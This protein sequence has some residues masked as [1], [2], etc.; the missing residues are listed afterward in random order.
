MEVNLN[1][2]KMG[3]CFFKG[4]VIFLFAL[5]CV[6]LIAW[7]IQASLLLN[8]DVSWLMHLT[9]RMLAGGTYGKDF[10]EANPPM[11]LYLYIPPV[12]VSHLF[13][14]NIIL[15][16]RLYVFFLSS[17]SLF[18][19]YLSLKKIISARY[20]FLFVLALL[21]LIFPSYEFG[22]REHLLIILIMPWLLMAVV[23]LQGAPVNFVCAVL[24]GFMAGVGFSIKPHFLLVFVLV[25][26]YYYWKLRSMRV[27]AWLAGSV[28][29][30]YGLSIFL[31]QPE[32]ISLVVTYAMLNYYQGF[33][34]PWNVLFLYPCAYFCCFVLLLYYFYGSRHTLNT[35]LA[36]ALC[37]FLVVWF[38]QRTIWYYHFLPALS[39]AVL[40][41][42]ILFY[43]A[44]SNSLAMRRADYFFVSILGLVMFF[45]PLY[46]VG[47]TLY[48]G[49]VTYKK[50]LSSLVQY[51]H[52]NAF[53]KKIYF[54]TTTTVY[55][56]PAVDYAGSFS[57][58]RFA[59]TGF[60]PGILKNPDEKNIRD[61]FI[62]GVA[63]DLRIKKP[64][65]IF[66]DVLSEKAH[67]D[68]IQFDY[69]SC[70]SQNKNFQDAWKSYH[71]RETI[72]KEDAYKF[73]VYQRG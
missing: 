73:E 66:V 35:V 69:L 8:W 29:V 26:L 25:E 16:L 42:S 15:S 31:F 50:P 32:Y 27:E 57:V 12:I 49:L 7:I 24:V 40:L 37:G 54:F 67:L 56:F 72:G 68:G 59:F 22:Q 53:K 63:E 39:M 71:Y 70:F 19:C 41:L 65:F 64:D 48:W 10:F 1:G 21:F 44:I 23:R 43:S 55:E 34:Y 28:I 62:N 45:L 13:F 18:L 38:V 46:C 2:E 6:Y 30:F 47:E 3:G 9:A 11:I 20:F 33:G 52:D 14:I 5:L 17:I 60:V 36:I 61:F 4:G 51:M 58:S